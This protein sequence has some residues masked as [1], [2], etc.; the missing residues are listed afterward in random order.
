MVVKNVGLSDLSLTRISYPS[1]DCDV[2]VGPGTGDGG[3]RYL[4]E[5]KCK[6]DFSAPLTIH[7]GGSHVFYVPAPRMVYIPSYSLG[8][9]HYDFQLS[10][11]KTII[12]NKE[13]ADHFYFYTGQLYQTTFNLNVGDST[14]TI[15]DIIGTGEDDF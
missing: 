1:S 15:P 5:T 7:P 3:G 12:I 11:G 4:G 6:M 14:G 10:N 8:P 13:V 2:W 9:L